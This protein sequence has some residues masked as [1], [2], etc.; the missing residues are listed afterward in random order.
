MSATPSRLFGV[1]RSPKLISARGVFK[2]L[3]FTGASAKN[4]SIDHTVFN[5]D[6]GRLLHQFKYL[7]LHWIM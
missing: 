1:I 3:K 5:E 4:D 6:I 7:L 2:K